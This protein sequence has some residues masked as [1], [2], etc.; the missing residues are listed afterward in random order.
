[1][2]SFLDS[3]RLMLSAF[4]ANGHP[5]CFHVGSD[6]QYG[7]HARRSGSGSFKARQTVDLLPRRED[8]R[9]L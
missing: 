9:P 6:V 8:V 2:S 5:H 7:S 3:I 4:P 1:M